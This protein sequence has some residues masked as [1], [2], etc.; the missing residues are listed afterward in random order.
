MKKDQ[1]HP[2]HLSLSLFL[3]PGFPLLSVMVDP[4]H[5]PVSRELPSSTFPAMLEGPT[6]GGAPRKMTYVLGS[7]VAWAQAGCEY[8]PLQAPVEHSS[9]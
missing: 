9:S 3:F 2:V 4:S 6:S 1:V 7:W 5:S 8:P